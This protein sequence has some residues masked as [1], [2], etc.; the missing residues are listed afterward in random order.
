VVTAI[1]IGLL[2]ISHVYAGAM[3][4]PQERAREV[5]QAWR[6]WTQQELPE[7]IISVGRILNPPPLPEVPEPV[8]GKRFVVIEAMYLGGEAEGVE[9]IAPLRRLGPAL[10]TFA[11][12][13]AVALSHLHMDPDHPV[14][15]RGD[16]MLIGS[17]SAEMIDA[18]VDASTGDAGSALLS[19][20]LRQLG[21]AIARRAS[22][23]GATGSIDA[24]YAM[25][26]VGAVPVP[27]AI[28]LVEAQVGGLKEA[29]APYDAGFGYLNFS[30]GSVDSRG[31]YRDE[32]T[33]RRLQAVKAAYDPAEAIQSNHPIAPA[34]R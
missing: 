16:G 2:P 28:P 9:L 19:A 24:D 29:L 8:R 23:Q 27:D 15:G 10:D 25:Y 17:T 33:Y 14:P 32:Y 34:R 22:G 6:E 12:I 1:E 4:W 11:T 30:E 21:G 18:F 5:L 3:F 13:P 20:E 31:L 7:E 26:A